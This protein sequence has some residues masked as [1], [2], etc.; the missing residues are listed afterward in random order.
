MYYLYVITY[1]IGVGDDDGHSEE[2]GPG[3][4]PHLEGPVYVCVYICVYIYIYIYMQMCVHIHIYAF[5]H[6]C[7]HICIYV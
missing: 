5:M 3:L 1:I 2:A 6:V 4:P 7:M